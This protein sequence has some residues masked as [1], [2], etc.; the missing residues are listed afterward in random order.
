MKAQK[1]TFKLL[2]YSGL[3]FIL[4]SCKGENPDKILSH[5]SGYWEIE[6]VTTI[7]GENK[8]YT[9]NM[10]VDYIEINNKEGF[11]K[12]VA[13]QLNGTYTITE[14]AEKIQVN[15]ENNQV[16]LEYSTPFDQWTETV[17][18]ADDNQLIIENENGITYTY[19]RFEPLN[20]TQ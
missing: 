6:Q 14:D 4:F 15:I 5:I 8:N 18:K 10:L 19:K 7:D 13:P 12:K 3:I 1:N 16:H 11:R 9:I 2:V 20:L 17:V